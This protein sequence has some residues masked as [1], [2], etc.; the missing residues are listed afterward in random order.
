MKTA[1]TFLRRRVVSVL[2]SGFDKR[3]AIRRATSRWDILGVSAKARS[4][5]AT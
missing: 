2:R 5:A 3:N 1:E 4:V